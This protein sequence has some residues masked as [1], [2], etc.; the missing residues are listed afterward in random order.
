M[1]YTKD[2][3]RTRLATKNPSNCMTICMSSADV[4]KYDPNSALLHWLDSSKR[5]RRINFMD[6]TKGP[7]YNINRVRVEDQEAPN[8]MEDQ[9]AVEVSIDHLFQ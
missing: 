6:P 3:R 8:A 4:G 1:N 7:A 5:K 9:P 2:D